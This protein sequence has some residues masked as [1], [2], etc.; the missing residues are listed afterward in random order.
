MPGAKISLKHRLFCRIFPQIA[1]YIP[2]R[3]AY[4]TSLG[5]GRALGFCVQRSADS[6]PMCR[7]GR[8]MIVGRCLRE[9]GILG[10]AFDLP[11]IVQGLDHVQAAHSQHRRLVLVSIHLP[12]NVCVHRALFPLGIPATI[13]TGSNVTFRSV[14]GI[15]EAPRPAIACPGPLLYFKVRSALNEERIVLASID[16]PSWYRDRMIGLTPGPIEFAARTETPVVFFATA[17]DRNGDIRVVF[18]RAHIGAILRD[19]AACLE[20]F[21][22]FMRPFVGEPDQFFWESRHATRRA[23]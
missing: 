11:L 8:S 2:D 9:F 13:I 21:A 22:T 1:A 4:L 15:P 23:A 14:C 20:S 6:Y 10:K 3:L 16:R 7:D 5:L 18:S 12:L 19:Q 17:L